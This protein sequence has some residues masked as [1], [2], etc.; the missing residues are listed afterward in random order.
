[1]LTFGGDP[2]NFQHFV[3]LMTDFIT[4]VSNISY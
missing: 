4:T 2:P 3:Q 1:M